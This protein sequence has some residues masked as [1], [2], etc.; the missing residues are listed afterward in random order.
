MLDAERR[1]REDLERKCA[2]AERKREEE[3]AAMD[4]SAYSLGGAAG[5][6]SSK[7]AAPAKPFFANS[8]MHC[9][10]TST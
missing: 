5:L 8:P 6:R 7:P 2:E 9:L 1:Q 10:V 3:R 4:A